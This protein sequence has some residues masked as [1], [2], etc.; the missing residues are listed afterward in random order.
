[1]VIILR[2]DFHVAVESDILEKKG[3]NPNKKEVV[4]VLHLEGPYSEES[5]TLVEVEVIEEEAIMVLLQDLLRLTAALVVV[6][7]EET[8]EEIFPWLKAPVPVEENCKLYIICIY[9]LNV[10]RMF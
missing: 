4:V 5:E 3:K 9:L 6:V 2:E 7:V 8:L 10:K 1:M